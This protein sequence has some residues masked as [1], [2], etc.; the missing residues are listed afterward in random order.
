MVYEPAGEMVHHHRRDSARKPLG[1][2]FWLHL[3]SLISFYEKWSL[4]VYVAKKWRRPVEVVLHWLLDMA[5]LVVA[6]LGAYALRWLA[7]PLFDTELLRLIWYRGWLAWSA[8]MVTVAFALMGRYGG[9]S[10][11]RGLRWGAHLRQIGMVALLLLAGSYLG[12]EQVVSRAV[13]VAFLGL[14]TLLSAWALRQAHAVHAR[15]ARGYLTL[16]RTLL[17]G[18]VEALSDWLHHGPDLRDQGVDVV[19]YLCEAP[20]PEVGL[21]ALG[22][23][24]VPWLGSPRDLPALVERFRVSEV[25]FWQRPANDPMLWGDLVRLRQSRIRLRWILDESWLLSVGARP[26]R[27]GAGNS[28]VLDP[29]DGHALRRW[30][31]RPLEIAVALPLLLVAVALSPWRRWRRAQGRLRTETASV[32]GGDRSVVVDSDGHVAPLWWQADLLRGLLTGR[33]GLTGA[34]L[35]GP[36]HSKDP[37]ALLTEVDAGRAGLTG[38]EHREGE[39]PPPGAGLWRTFFMNPGGWDRRA[40]AATAAPEPTGGEEVRGS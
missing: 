18:P 32:S 6:L 11:R 23:G 40:E 5:L 3:T 9:A 38:H 4:L 2:S 19:G 25:A 17:V 14:Y 35:R 7:Q 29:D 30:A 8:V 31:L 16:Q 13:L 34:P 33:L 27:F 28:G 36:I 26:E 20:Q 22:R 12:R 37:A 15:L 10:L 21:P 24:E 1:K 39:Q